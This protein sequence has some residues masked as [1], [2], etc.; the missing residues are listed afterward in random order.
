MELAR[1]IWTLRGELLAMSLLGVIWCA[2][3]VLT[4]RQTL[5]R[6]GLES[7]WIF[8]GFAGS[9][10][11]ILM[12]NSPLG[13]LNE[14]L[15]VQLGALVMLAGIVR[16]L[17]G[18][19]TW[20]VRWLSPGG[21]LIA[22]AS[23]TLLLVLP[24]TARNVKSVVTAAEAKRAGASLA[25]AEVFQAGPLDD[26]QIA[27]FG[28][29]PPLPTTYVGKVMDGIRLLNRIGRADDTVAALDFSNPFNVARGVPPSRTAPTAWQLGF[30]YTRRSAPSADRV[31][32]GRDVIM[33][34]KRFGD[35]NQ[36]NLVVLRQLYG[37]YLDKHYRIAGESQQ[38]QALVPR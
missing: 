15:I 21:A 31:F 24:T 29:D 25:Q 17:R 30:V 27:A 34:A 33:I 20:S 7:G 23:L 8:S 37:S 4:G 10:A 36:A 1:W 35:G 3:G 22:A 11:A 26:L 5:L 9:A 28:G 12:T 13:A 16:D 14:T 32:N 18:G 2:T 6:R 19:G 38:W